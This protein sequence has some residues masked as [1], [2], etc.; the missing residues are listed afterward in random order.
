[1]GERIESVCTR[2]ITIGRTDGTKESDAF[3]R[4]VFKGTS[5][6]VTIENKMDDYLKVHGCAVLPLVF[7]SYKAEGN[8]KRLKHDKAYS[9]KIMD[10]TVE[11][12][13]VL[14]K[15]G[16][17]ILPHGEYE[18]CTEKKALGAFLYRFMF[19]NFL[20]KLCIS[21]HAMNAREEFSLMNLEFEK[22]KEKA[23]VETPV[24]DTLKTT[25]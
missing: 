2:K 3:I 17:E 24:Y 4:S 19:S 9:M 14:K 21:D 20:G 1:N 8:L 11:G 23:G 12:Y 13:D 25:L 16:Y 7:A 18:N 6:K 15:L 22:L 5:I 10:A